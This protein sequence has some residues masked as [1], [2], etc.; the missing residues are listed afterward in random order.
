MPDWWEQVLA[1]EGRRE[2]PGEEEEEG[3]G[4]AEQGEEG[5]G[6]EEEGEE[7]EGPHQEGRGW[8]VQPLLAGQARR[9]HF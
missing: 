6:Q 5:E 4:L 7:G 9:W 1:W 3:E 2:Q 8:L